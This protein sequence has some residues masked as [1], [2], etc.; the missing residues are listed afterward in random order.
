M[1]RLK[2]LT[3]ML[4]I[5]LP[6]LTGCFGGGSGSSNPVGVSMSNSAPTM[7]SSSSQLLASK[8]EKTTDRKYTFA[9]SNYKVN[10]TYRK[11][12]ART[13]ASLKVLFQGVESAD[14]IFIT[15]GS[16]VVKSESGV[17]TNISLPDNRVDL[18]DAT[19]LA[20]VL[21]ELDLPAGIYTQLDVTIKSAEAIIGG[22]TVDLTVPSGRIRFNGIIELKDGYTTN[23]SL[24][25]LGRLRNGKGKG[26]N[27]LMPVVKVVCELVAK[28]V[29]VTDGDISGS[30]ENFVNAQKL[31]GVNVSL[32]GTAFSTVTDA[33]GA[34]SFA[35]VPAGIYTLKA[36]HPDYLDY[37]LSVSVEA[38]QVA[39]V[40]VQINPAVIHSTVG[41]TGWFAE[42]YPLAD[43]NGDYA[44]V[45]LETPVNIDFVSL[46]F[47]KAEMKFTAE[48]YA[49][50]SSRCLNYLSSTQQV[51]AV[52]DLG[53]WWAGNAAVTG[54]YLGEFYCTTN[55]GTTYT[56][57]VTEMIRSNPSSS[58]FMA[59]KNIGLVSIRM[60]NVQLSVYYR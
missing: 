32:D 46:A 29:Q 23:L 33:N 59:S 25:F 28:P 5:V 54:S 15:C 10:Y 7:D 27:K 31:A 11:G 26:N 53:S 12:L 3:L 58:Y 4:V 38:G 55:P 51:S 57:D 19:T 48:Y 16:M 24:R 56:V 8:F 35:K 36:S 50:G 6:L 2:L 22:K 20:K 9:K 21:A 1:N 39:T 43:A 37:S 44:E 42:I 45:A 13:G 34:F 17:Y 14:N 41:N 30:V 18:K 47:V 40:N 60:T 49:N 52:A